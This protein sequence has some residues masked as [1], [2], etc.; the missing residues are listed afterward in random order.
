VSR[1]LPRARRAAAAAVATGLMLALTGCGAGFQAQTY[2]ERTVADVSNTAVGALA[3]RALSVSPGSDGELRP[4]DDADVQL[5]VVNEG[6]EADRLVEVTSPAAESVDIIETEGGTVLDELEIPALGTTG[7]SAGLVLRGLTER[8]L[9][10]ET[11]EMTLR[12]ERNGEV[13]VSVPVATTGRY[14]EDRERSENF[15]LPGEHGG[16]GGGEGGEH[17]GE[18]SGHEAGLD[19]ASEDATEGDHSS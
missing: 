17:G 11:V 7:G 5:V 19:E 16:H 15:P 4:G 9:A 14:D 12:F 6:A 10:G 13:T 3:L 8:V 18:E 1:V 2:Q